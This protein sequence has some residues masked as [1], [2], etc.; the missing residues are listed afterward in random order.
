MGAGEAE[1]EPLRRR[2]RASARRSP[3]RARSGGEAEGGAETPAPEFAAAERKHTPAAERLPHG[4]GL[5]APLRLGEGE[6]E[7]AQARGGGNQGGPRACVHGRGNCG[8]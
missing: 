5:G 2:R 4:E 3:R 6:G 7:G 8:Y 1:G